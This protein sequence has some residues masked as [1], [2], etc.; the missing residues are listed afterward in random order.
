M[1]GQSD[2]ADVVQQQPKTEETTY[3]VVS[4]AQLDH[5]DVAH[6][7]PNTDTTTNQVVT[8]AQSDHADVAHHQPDTDM[9]TNQVVT[10]AQSDDT[11]LVHQ[12]PDTDMTTN[13][14]VSAASSANV[15]VTTIPETSLDESLDPNG[16]P[17]IEVPLLSD[18]GHRIFKVV[19]PLSD[20]CK[21]P[22]SAIINSETNEKFSLTDNHDL[23]LE[24]SCIPV[25]DKLS[26]HEKD[27]LN[28]HSS[29]IQMPGSKS[30]DG[31]PR[32]SSQNSEEP[33]LV[34]CTSTLPT[35][36]GID[37]S[38]TVCTD[39]PFDGNTLSIKEK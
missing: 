37:K 24:T 5:T 21:L 6:H 18:S 16:E 11:D 33:L 28:S 29:L 19:V 20:F 10:A 35:Q 38:G 3:H 9:T 1:E 31:V 30:S 39:F 7:Q 14:V 2:N 22:V 23:Q 8:A 4:L 32:K 15:L 13:Q 26:L 12:Q 27:D 36:V 25:P 34:P 17:Q